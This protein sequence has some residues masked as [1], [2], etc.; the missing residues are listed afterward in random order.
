[1]VSE[2]N[3]LARARKK[4]IHGCETMPALKNFCKSSSSSCAQNSTDSSL[5]RRRRRREIITAAA[6]QGQRH[7]LL[8]E[9]WIHGATRIAASVL[10][11]VAVPT[12]IQMNQEQRDSVVQATAQAGEQPRL[13]SKETI[14][15]S[16]DEIEEAEVSSSRPRQTERR[17]AKKLAKSKTRIDDEEAFAARE[18]DAPG[19]GMAKREL[20]DELM[21]ASPAPAEI[22]G[23]AAEGAPAPE[24]AKVMPAAPASRAMA[25]KPAEAKPAAGVSRSAPIADAQANLKQERIAEEEKA[26]MEKLWK[27]FEKDPEGISARPETQRPSQR[28]CSPATTPSHVRG[29]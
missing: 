19:G 5:P 20:A 6:G 4:D 18:K 24:S 27:E 2:K 26:E 11:A 9:K 14:T 3:T 17:A 12:V 16:N 7:N 8:A 13:E 25:E 29:E 10:L 15:N 28:P 1:L 21:A 22:K 23:R